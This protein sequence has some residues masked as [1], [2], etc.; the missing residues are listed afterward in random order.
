MLV[1]GIEGR[2]AQAAYDELL[3]ATRSASTARARHFNVIRKLMNGP[4][5]SKVAFTFERAD[6]S[7]FDATLPRR[8]IPRRH[9]EIH[10]VLPSGYGY[11][12]FSQWTVGLTVRALAGLEE[13]RATPGLVID[14]R[15]NPGGSVYAVNEMLEKFFT[16]RTELGRTTTRSGKPVSMF[17]G[18]V[19]IIKLEREVPGDPRAYRA[20]VVILV[21]GLSAS[22]SE[23]FAGSMQAAGRAK[24]VGEPSCGCLLGFLGYARIPNGAEL[25]YSEVGFVLTNGKHVEGE[26][27]IPDRLVPH[28]LEDLRVSRDRAL[29]DA[30]AMLATMATGKKEKDDKM[31]ARQ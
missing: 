30:Q 1:V 6:A 21:D 19:D 31:K 16:E 20:P 9:R 27:V 3:A 25:A 24:V 4:E 23:L 22:G 8:A 11:L 10:R 17:M 18:A 7:R 28:T 2:P 12:R 29:E 13:L 26:G 15:G 5:G 14:L